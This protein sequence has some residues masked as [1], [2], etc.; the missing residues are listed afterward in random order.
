MSVRFEKRVA[1]FAVAKGEVEVSPWANALTLG[2]A[3]RRAA[4]VLE[5]KGFWVVDDHKTKR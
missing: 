4:R 2:W 5:E 1:F 3:E